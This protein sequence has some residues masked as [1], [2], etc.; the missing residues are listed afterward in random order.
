[1]IPSRDVQRLVE[2]MQALRDPN[3][4][5]PWDI[6]QTHETIVPYTIEETY[7]VVDAIERRDMPDLRDELGD[8]LLQVVYHAQLA[9]ERG[10][11]EFGDVVQSITAKMIRRHPHVFGDENAKDAGSAKGTWERIKSEEKRLRQEERQRL[12]LPNEAV[13]HLA[14]VSRAM[15]G[16]TEALE[17]SKRAAKVGFDW[18]NVEDVVRKIEE[19]LEEVRQALKGR[20]QR[21]IQEEIGDL[22]FAVVNLARHVDANVETCIR[23]TNAKF[24]SRFANVERSLEQS[25]RTLADATLEEMEDAWVAAKSSN[26]ASGS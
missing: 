11:F 12:G 20:E 19:E 22:L 10:D 17:L 24:R 26:Q 14:K 2:I 25:N 6:V 21:A 5:C 13:G 4:G 23:A 3:D 18:P 1:M 15:P 8:M 7:E 9:A 16:M